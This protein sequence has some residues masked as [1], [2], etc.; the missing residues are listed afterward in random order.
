MRHIQTFSALTL[1]GAMKPCLTTF[2]SGLCCSV[3]FICKC[4]HHLWQGKKKVRVYLDCRLDHFQSET[5]KVKLQSPFEGIK[6]N[7]TYLKLDFILFCTSPHGQ[8][9]WQWFFF[10]WYK[11][12]IVENKTNP[13]CMNVAHQLSRW[14]FRQGSPYIEKWSI[15]CVCCEWLLT[16]KMPK[17]Y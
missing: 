13:E 7:W 15:F 3:D 10:L 8:T 5:L 9:G 4:T 11:S 16:I 17:I 6:S 1:S 12:S 14:T 2:S